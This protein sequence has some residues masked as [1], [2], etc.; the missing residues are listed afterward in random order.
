M[1]TFEIKGFWG[2]L[3][4]AFMSIVILFITATLPVAFTWV[5]WN[6]FVGEL[7]HGPLIDLWQAVILAAI[8]GISLM[9]L[10]QPKVSFQI[11]RVQSPEELEKHLQHLREK[12]SKD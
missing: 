5:A 2:F 11:K 4:F 9:L 1:K 8:L 10:F 6:A 7:F 12:D 3:F